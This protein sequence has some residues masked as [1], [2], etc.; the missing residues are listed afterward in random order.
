MAVTAG[1]ASDRPFTEGHVY[2]GGVTVYNAF[3]T[4][5]PDA[6]VV[7]VNYAPFTDTPYPLP[8]LFYYW[9]P[10]ERLQ[11][12]IGAPFFVRWQFAPRWA[13]DLLW[14]PVR[15]VNTRVTWTSEERPG[16]HAYGAFA[17]SNETWLLSNRTDNAD[18]F[19]GYDK[20]LFG[21]IQFDLP[22]KLRLD[23]A[24]GYVFDRFYFQ[25]RTYRDRM[26]DRVN[27]GGGVF[28]SVQLRLQF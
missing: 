6:W 10:S 21:G 11:M 23:L 20:R 28:G 16:F 2:I 17:W 4:D 22:Y 26:H 18:R 5:G 13:F 7:G 19:F 14:I 12:A 15:T 3:P 9:Q 24:A 8:V 25:G 1:S 27:I